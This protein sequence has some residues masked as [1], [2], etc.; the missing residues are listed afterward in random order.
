MCAKP[1]LLKACIRMTNLVV[2]GGREVGKKLR[3]CP[4]QVMLVRSYVYKG[5]KTDFLEAGRS[6]E[7]L[8]FQ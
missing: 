6:N 3:E 8:F 5:Q 7:K 2:L 1:M 4:H